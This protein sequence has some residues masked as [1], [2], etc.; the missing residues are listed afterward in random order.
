MKCLNLVTLL[1]FTCSLLA[2]ESGIRGYVYDNLNSEVLIGASIVSG[3]YGTTTDIDGRFNLELPTGEYEFTV[4]YIGYSD[5]NIKITVTE[6]IKELNLGLDQSST[7]LETTTVTGSKHEKSIAESPVSISIIQTQLI[8]NTNTV[9]ISEVLDKVPGVQ[10]K[11]NQANI[12]GGSGWSYGAGSR[13]LLLIDDIPALQADAGRPT[14]GD[15]PVENISQIEVLKGAASTL[16]GSSAL[17]GIINI[18]TGYATSEPVTKAYTSYTHYMSPKD[19]QKQWWTDAPSKL[20]VGLLHKQK[21][22]K[23]DVVTHGFYEDFDSFYEDGYDRKLR[24]SANL[25]YRLSDKVNF[26]INTMYNDGEAADYFIWGNGSTGAYKGFDG[27]FSVREN[28]RFYIDPQVTIFDNKNNKHRIFGRYYYINNDNSGGQSNSSKSYYAEYQFSRKFENLGFNLTSGA[29]AYLTSSNSELF[30]DGRITSDNFAGYV[31]LDKTFADKL[32]VTAGL[33]MENNKQSNPA[34]VRIDTIP[35][36]EKT[37]TRLISRLGLNYQLFDYTWLRAS[38]GEGYRFP[39]ITERFI[40]TA[41]G[42]FFIFPNADL[43]SETG[44]SSELGIKQGLKISQW[45]AFVDVAFFWSKYSNMTEFT[46][47]QDP[48]G[49][50]GFQSQNVGGTDIKG[51]EIELMGRSKLFS[52]PINIIAGYTY[53]DPRYV[54]FENNALVFNSISTPIGSDTKENVLKY[55]NKH[56]FKIDVETIIDGFSMGLALNYTS[57]TVT[58]DQLLGNIA[59]I[60]LY[61]DVNPGGYLRFDGRMAYKFKAFKLSVLMSNILNEEYTNRPGL[62]EAPRNLAMRLDFDF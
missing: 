32:T 59:Q 36:G 12:R 5:L 11:D 61:R 56:N 42:G 4:T 22:G 41:V 17:N 14:W 28:Q 62:L 46:L 60:R 20:N 1:L 21:F 47:Q 8:E 58:I 54:D 15:I 27:T 50:F 53:I 13:V 33:R 39:T 2:Q 45:E 38:W 26:G 25:K 23:L 40:E 6:G 49:N 52:I 44:W 51:F 34:I 18:R 10:I 3:E 55:R 7:I 16:Y 30:G 57:E 9:K 48:E 37:G 35:A 31:E 19:P 43:Q 29:L 24:Y